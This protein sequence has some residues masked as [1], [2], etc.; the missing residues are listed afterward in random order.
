LESQDKRFD[1]RSILKCAAMLGGLH[2]GGIDGSPALAASQDDAGSARPKEGDVLVRIENGVP[3]PLS[4]MD[5]PER[6]AP[7]LVWAMDPA[8]R[9]V[10]NGSR[11]N[12]IIVM[13]FEPG[14]LAARTR[15]RSADGV[16]AY[17]AICTHGGCE[18]VD[19]L[20][21]EKALSCSCHSSLFDPADEATVISGPAPRPL[22]ALPLAVKD[23]SLVVAAPFTS[24]VSF[25][26]A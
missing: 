5:V 25:E 8:T 12:Q 24:T 11:L 2:L 1:R 20:A 14:E 17:T 26:S 18:V 10:R 15:T 23:R 9:A 4:P 13:R 16:V 3:V 19:W 22:P 6:S 7:L 21:D